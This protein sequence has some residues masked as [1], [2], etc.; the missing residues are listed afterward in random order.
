[1]PEK[2]VFEEL[3]KEELETLLEDLEEELL[4]SN[5]L[6][7]DDSCSLVELLDSSLDA[8][9]L[10]KLDGSLLCSFKLQPPTMEVATR[11]I[12]S[13]ENVLFFI[14]SFL[15]NLLKVFS[16]VVI[17]FFQIGH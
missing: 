9:V 7:L 3:F 16:I 2:T 13:L 17:I 12:I 6:L 4:D 11:R 8:G 5:E 1:M 10:E 14:K 15:S